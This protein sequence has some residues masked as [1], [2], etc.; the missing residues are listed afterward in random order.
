MSKKRFKALVYLPLKPEKAKAYNLPL[1]LPVRVEDLPLI[2]DED[3][4]PL[5]VIVRGLEEEYKVSG[6]EY[7][8]TYLVYFYYEKVKELMASEKYDEALKYVEKAGTLERDYR[9]H[10]YRGLV[11]LKTGKD[12]E[13]VVELKISSGLNSNFILADYELAR[14]YLKRGEYD[15][16]EK[17]FR[18]VL[19]RDPDFPL[20]CVG[21]GDVHLS[22]GDVQG[23]V[24]YYKKALEEE[25]NLPDVYNRLGVIMNAL[26]RF[27][28]AK[29]YFERA[30]SIFPDYDDAKFNL[31]YTLL[32]LGKI[33]DSLEL[34]MNLEK[35]RP[36]DPAILNELGI[37]MRELG[38]F[39]ESVERLEKAL[40][41][42]PENEGIKLN[43]ARSLLFVDKERA[44][45][46]L[47]SIDGEYK[48]LAKDLLDYMGKRLTLDRF[49]DVEYRGETLLS[50]IRSFGEFGED[51][52]ELVSVFEF[53]DEELSK[54]ADAISQGFV[55]KSGSDVDT[56]E[57]LEEAFC[58][59]LNSRDFVEMERRSIML[60]GA[61]YGS[62]RMLAVVRALLRLVQM[63]LEL[64]EILIEEFLDS[65]VPEIQDLDWEFALKISRYA[66][67]LPSYF[68]KTGTDFFLSL[69]HFLKTGETPS[70]YEFFLKLLR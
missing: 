17:G 16:A 68:P 38:L 27:K 60:A 25:N 65:L 13:A 22:Q 33:F 20:A 9:Y 59:I 6:N 35:K 63:K 45:E 61:L 47:A 37:A 1:K 5:D 18:R 39:E 64:G 62:G 8:K 7:Y 34:L 11:M 36:N 48:A 21:L 57:F 67:R 28:E 26:Q 15:D 10:F 51:I 24:E 54:R 44:E 31:S 12:S 2:A 43:L 55:M 41:F 30:I 19:E 70:G 3:K 4:L 69:L 49:E 40:K 23:A 53:S 56:V 14:Y 29:H 42:D 32:R 66:D 46:L 50:H 58:W 52:A